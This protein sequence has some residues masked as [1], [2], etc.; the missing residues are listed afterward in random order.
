MFSDDAAKCFRESSGVI[1]F[2][3]VEPKRLFVEVPEQVERLDRNV[4]AADRTLEQRPEVFEPVGVDL[5]ARIRLGVINDVVGVFAREPFIGFECVGV[6]FGSALDVLTDGGL[7]DVL[8]WCRRPARG[9]C[10]FCLVRAAP[11]AP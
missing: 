9:P 1:V 8:A 6:D 5:P 11:R 10:W 3:F 4:G 2:R 7:Q